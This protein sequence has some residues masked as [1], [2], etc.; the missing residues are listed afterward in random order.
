M[1]KDELSL[2]DIILFLSLIGML[3]SLVM[4]VGTAGAVECEKLTILEGAKR[5]IIW[6][7]IL[8]LSGIGIIKIQTEEESEFDD[9]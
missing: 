7:I 5:E 6:V 9:L 4:M 2:K 8:I 3:I 1:H